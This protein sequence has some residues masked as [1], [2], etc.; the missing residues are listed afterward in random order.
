[1]KTYFKYFR[2]PFIIA[3]VITIVSLT[4]YFVAKSTQADVERHNTKWDYTNT[5]F[6]YADKMTDSEERALSER[7]IEIEDECR[8]DIVFM[9]IDDPSNAY[10]DSV[11]SMADRFSEDNSMGYDFAGGSAIV[12]IDNW[13]R[14]G[15]GGV[16]FW[17]STTGD[18]RNRISDDDVT[19][20]K[21]DLYDLSD[22]DD[23][24]YV[25]SK[26][27]EGIYKKGGVL[28][29]PY[30]MGI[31]LIVALVIAIIY[32]FLNWRSKLGDVTVNEMTYLDEGQAKFT[33]KSDTFTHKTVTKRKIERS[34]GSGGVGGGGSHG[35]GG[36]SR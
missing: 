13:S 17:L 25:Y 36:G 30:S 21:Q 18:I 16:H 29:P 7:L 12:F 22:G 5:V 24:Y 15:D 10:L 6:D 2:I 32:I 9:T 19:D 31:V 33:H 4:A 1:M 8:A 27:A 20:I 14:G 35:G 23:P 34:S 28:A 11:K 26:L 3:A